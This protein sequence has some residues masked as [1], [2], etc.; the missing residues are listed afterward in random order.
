VAF[1]SPVALRISGSQHQVPSPFE[2][3]SDIADEVASHVR[4]SKLARLLPARAASENLLKCRTEIKY[5][6]TR[7]QKFFSEN[8]FARADAAGQIP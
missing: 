4:T 7:S 8:F 3:R 2:E 5:F 6:L 1:S